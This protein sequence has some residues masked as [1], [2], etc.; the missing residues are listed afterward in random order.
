MPY[1]FPPPKFAAT[2]LPAIKAQYYNEI[3]RARLDCLRDLMRME[4][5]DRMNDIVNPPASAPVTP[6]PHS[7]PSTVMNA[8]SGYMAAPVLYQQ[9]YARYNA[10]TIAN[11]SKWPN[12]DHEG[13]ECLYMIVMASV[14]QQGDAREVFKSSDVGDTDEDG[15]PEFLD[16]WNRPIDFIRWAPGYLSV[17][18]TPIRVTGTVNANGQTATLNVTGNYGQRLSQTPGSYIGGAAILIDPTTQMMDTSKMG[19]ITGYNYTLSPLS[20]TFSFEVPSMSMLPPT[21]NP[22]GGSSTSGEF[23]ILQPDPFDSRGSYPWYAAASTYPAL[24]N[25]TFRLY[26]LIL[27]AGPDKVFGIIHDWQIP[28]GSGNYY[29]AA[30]PSVRLNPFYVPPP[31][32]ESF[33]QALARRSITLPLPSQIG[34]AAAMSTTSR[35]TIS[36]R[37]RPCAAAG[38]QFDAGGGVG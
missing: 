15:L 26:P 8:Y 37:G 27:S 13:A 38:G 29:N 10:A 34:I 25:P 7:L 19:R 30:A 17:L 33:G 22:F 12:Y 5:P 21:A 36:I 2:A 32:S 31:I 35:T 24:A 16:G 9:Y 18:Q 4:M 23:V 20:V 6:F 28:A 14:A 3:S 11:P 1:T